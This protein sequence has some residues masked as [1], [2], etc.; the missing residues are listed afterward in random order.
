MRR[1]RKEKETLKRNMYRFSMVMACFLIG[2]KM[3]PRFS[4]DYMNIGH[5][6]IMFSYTVYAYDKN[7]YT[8]YN[9]LNYI[10]KYIII[11]C[12]KDQYPF[13]DKEFFADCYMMAQYVYTTIGTESKLHD[14][15]DFWD[16][17]S[18]NYHK[19]L[20]RIDE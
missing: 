12:K 14:F 18:E 13:F 19:S 2:K 15:K 7:S 10:T 6:N 1:S 5:G 8:F 20:E 16:R 9:P 17:L 4:D 3:N 11:S